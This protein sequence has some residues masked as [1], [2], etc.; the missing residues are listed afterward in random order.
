MYCDFVSYYI[1]QKQN[2][3]HS[4]KLMKIMSCGKNHPQKFIWKIENHKLAP[5]IIEKKLHK[6]NNHKTFSL[7]TNLIYIKHFE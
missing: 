4:E 5:L 2:L 6:Y 3:L 1:L 7:K